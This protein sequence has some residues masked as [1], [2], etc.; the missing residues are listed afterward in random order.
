MELR[1]LQYFAIVAEH[2]N[3]GRAAEALGLTA[4]ALTKCLR[5]LE[6]SVGAKLVQRTSKGVS[7]TAV[8]VSLLT[9]IGPLQGM[10]NDV[11]HE[12]ADL[13]LGRTGHI[14][15]GTTP[16]TIEKR[17][18]SA[19]VSLLKESPAITVK[20]TVGDNNILSKALHKGEI[21]FCI[22]G[23]LLLPLAEFTQEHP[24]EDPYVV[25]ASAHHRLAKRKLVSI[26][27]L[28]GERWATSN[29][30]SLPQWQALFRAF[31]NNGLPPPSMALETN[32]VAF[33]T[34]AIAN[35]EYVGLCSR[36]LLREE[37]RRY[38]LVE[39]PVKEM[40]HVRR[41]FIIHRKGAYLS[42][43]AQRLIA[44]LKTQAK[45]ISEGERAARMK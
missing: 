30:T 22:A 45:E 10:L 42:P 18:A 8:G 27:D 35:S 17:L 12:A 37:A 9:R 36:L 21:D 11:R 31:E 34:V 28:A 1:D 39:L 40:S 7:L 26:T 16:G 43:A 41:T 44:I 15:V 32:S 14:N 20:V 23:R 5:R 25:F 33:R 19:Y 38:P 6:K 13:A 2:Q 24:Y 29:S 4:T 3:V